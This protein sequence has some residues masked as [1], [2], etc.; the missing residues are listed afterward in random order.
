MENI[1][2]NL[3]SLIAFAIVMLVAMLLLALKNRFSQQ[4][5]KLEQALQ[6]QEMQLIALQTALSQ[7]QA[8]LEASQQSYQASQLENEQVSK[9][10]EHRIKVMQTQFNDKWQVI[11]QQLQQQPEDKL[12]SRAQKLVELG[13]DIAEIMREC[14]IPRAEAEMLLAIHRQKASKY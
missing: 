7:N 14:D 5:N 12:Y 3:I 1:P 6:N 13:A 4:I 11:E 8:L 10:L 2:A 9:Q